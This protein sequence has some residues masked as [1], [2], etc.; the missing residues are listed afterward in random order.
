MNRARIYR[1]YIRNSRDSL[2]PKKQEEPEPIHKG[3]DEIIEK[4]KTTEKK[5]S[6]KPKKK[7]K[8]KKYISL[9]YD[10]IEKI[11]L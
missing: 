2:I 4:S 6:N 3:D 7:R 1:K 5:N 8:E 9:S 11:C 10:N